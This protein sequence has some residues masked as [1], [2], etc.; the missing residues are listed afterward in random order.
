MGVIVVV[1]GQFGSEGKGKVIVAR[2]KQSLAMGKIPWFVRC[3]GPNSGHTVTIDGVDHALRQ[4]PSGAGFKESMLFMSAGCV[5]NVQ[6]LIEEAAALN[7]SK[8]RLVIDPRCVII[9]QSD[10]DNEQAL[11]GK[12]GSTASGTGY[13]MSRRM[14]RSDGVRCAGDIPLLA[15]K[16]TVDTVAPYLHAH[17]DNGDDV[18]VEGTQGFGL[19]LLHSPFY[20]QTTSRDTTAGQYVVEAGLSPMQVTEIIMCL[21]TFPIRVG[22]NSGPMGDETTWKEIQKISGSPDYQPELTSVTRR[23]RR[24]AHFD[25]SMVKVATLYNRPTSIAIMGVDRLDHG[26]LGIRDVKQ[27]THRAYRWL[28]TMQEQVG[29]AFSFLGTGPAQD[30]II[31]V[32]SL[33]AHCPS[34]T[35]KIKGFSNNSALADFLNSMVG[36]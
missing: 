35:T 5:I 1:G 13:A 25:V 34:C 7:I 11:V 14:L 15:E 24:V 4:I 20:P 10:I 22:G 19:S 2:G 29:V 36:K 21:R 9:E 6:R 26:N 30:D 8:S 31:A 3:G 33:P 32:N 28:R 17:I 12:V 16:F 27:L 23:E 18:I